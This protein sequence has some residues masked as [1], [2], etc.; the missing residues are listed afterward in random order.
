MI[1][2]ILLVLMALWLPVGVQA[3]SAYEHYID[4]YADMAVVPDETLRHSG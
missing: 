4:K 2:K 1:H 3:Q